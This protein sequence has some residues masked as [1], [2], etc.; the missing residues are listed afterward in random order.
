MTDPTLQTVFIAGYS[1]YQQ[2]DALSAFIRKAAWCIM[3]CRSAVMGGHIQACPDGHFQR[4]HYKSCKYRMCPGCAFIQVQNWLIKQKARILACSH[5][6]V[7][8][9]IPHELNFLLRFN[10][11][12]ITNIL[13]RCYLNTLFELLQDEKYLGA[14]PGII[15]SFHYWTKTLMLHP[16][17]HCLLTAGGLNSGKWESIG[18]FLFP[19]AVARDL[20][21]GK[22]RDDLLKALDKGQMVLPENISLTKV[23]NL[24]NK[25]GR[26]KWDVKVCDKYT[27][28]NGVLT[29]LARYLRGGPISNSRLL[30]VEKE[31]ATF[32]IGRCCIKPL[33]LPILEFFHR[34]VQHIPKPHSILVRYYGLYSSS[35]SEELSLCRVILGQGPVEDPVR[36]E[37][38]DL[39]EDLFE[40][41]EE[42][43]WECPVCGKRLIRKPGLFF[44]DTSDHHGIPPPFKMAA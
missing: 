15:S 24:L 6:H 2:S 34:F 38:K 13:F 31:E 1:A 27:H 19:L 25:L 32:N 3:N 14:K 17:I 21:R 5:Y 37:C 28:G 29:Y 41:G 8:F 43:P 4:N 9:T 40:E 11:K 42:R 44:P 39:L 16:H 12:S 7:I 23:K 20:F 33:S 36:T 10:P 26:K 30:S 22:V 18:D 35:K